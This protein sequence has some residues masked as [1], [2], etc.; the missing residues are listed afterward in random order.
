MSFSVARIQNMLLGVTVT[1][2]AILERTTK[3]LQRFHCITIK[4]LMFSQTTSQ[5]K[6]TETENGLH[7][8]PV[9]KWKTK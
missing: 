9:I 6:Q 3:T 4:D 7:K 1:H 8:F 2:L 5:Y